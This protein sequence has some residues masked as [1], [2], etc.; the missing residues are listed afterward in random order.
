MSTSMLMGMPDP[1]Q[2][3]RVFEIISTSNSSYVKKGTENT[4]NPVHLNSQK[5]KNLCLTS[6]VYLGANKGYVPIQY[7]PYAPVIHVPDI[8]VDKDGKWHSLSEKKEESWTL[9]KGLESLGYNLKQ[10]FK[11]ALAKEIKFEFGRLF[12]D[13]YED[14]PALLQY[15]MLCQNNE[16]SQ[17]S[18]TFNL[19]KFRP[20][21]EETKAV[22]RLDTLDSEAEAMTYVSQL[23]TKNKDKY[24]FTTYNI[25]KLNATM[26]V[27]GLSGFAAD[28]YNQ[29]LLAVRGYAASKPTEFMAALNGA[30]DEKRMQIVGAL[31]LKVLTIKKNEIHLYT[32]DKDGLPTNRKILETISLN[33]ETQVDELASY[34]L[35]EYG[36]IDN[37]DMFLMSE[38]VKTEK[39]Q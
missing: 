29:K 16:K 10:E 24:E 26:R 25:N 17:G 11:N 38:T 37:R 22:K 30:F 35:T 9:I 2:K 23:R 32:G 13:K 7:V 4:A 1:A 8:Y 18:N 33:K 19:F 39:L 14:D 21:Q 20:L 31:E 3:I 5:T 15:L 6:K 28:D 12:L 36:A 27:L 34:L